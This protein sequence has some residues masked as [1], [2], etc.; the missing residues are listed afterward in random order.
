MVR[1]R[2]L[3]SGDPGVGAVRWERE[4][5]RVTDDPGA[6][7]VDF[8]V[9]VLHSTYWGADRPRGVIE[10]SLQNSVVLSLFAGKEQ[11]GLARLVSD[12]ATFAWLA[13]VY[14]HPDYRGRG[15]G[16]WLVGCALEHPA[17][18]VGMNLLSTR[19]AHGL[20]EKFGFHRWEG[21]VRLKGREGT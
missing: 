16:T 9:G 21:M 3:G 11:I 18:Q 6:V 14:V 4:G 13:D 8:V 15:L 12:R 10:C 1:G 17:A 19:D 20:Y 5:F 7:D 2:E